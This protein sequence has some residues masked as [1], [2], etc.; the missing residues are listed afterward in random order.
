MWYGIG[1]LKMNAINAHTY[2]AHFQPDWDKNA[3]AKNCSAFVD[4]T[5]TRL[6]SWHAPKELL[7]LA[8]QMGASFAAQLRLVAVLR[9]PVSRHLSWYNHRLS[10][11]N[12][13][14]VAKEKRKENEAFWNV[15]KDRCGTSFWKP[16]E[17]MA[18]SH[19][20]LAAC[21]LH[22][23]RVGGCGGA[24]G[25]G[26]SSSAVDTACWLT[27]TQTWINFTWFVEGLYAPQIDYWSTIWPRKQLLVLDFDT[28]LNRKDAISRVLTFAGVNSGRG[29][30]PTIPHSNEKPSACKAALVECATLHAMAPLIAPWNEALYTRLHADTLSGRAP[31]M[32]PPFK[33]FALPTKC[34][35]RALPAVNVSECA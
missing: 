25:G 31:S 26:N 23:W 18:P 4:G 6:A 32:E 34:E 29:H 11:S 8:S 1:A 3:D 30:T 21:D 10:T 16:R 13:K 14:L 15:V 24:S 22:R 7:Q 17:G 28:L 20:M 5:P 33:P 12:I 2:S 27:Q 35:R 9:E 19:A